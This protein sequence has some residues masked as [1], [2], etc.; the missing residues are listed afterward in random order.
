MMIENM[1]SPLLIVGPPRSGTSLVRDLVRLCP[2]VYVPPD[3]TQFLV[4]YIRRASDG[5]SR[6]DL[7]MFLDKTSFSIHMRR[8]GLWPDRRTLNRLL[9]VPQPQTAIPLLFAE[10]A[11]REGVEKITIW[12]DKTP[13]YALHLPLIRQIYPDLRVLAVVRDPRNVV[14]SMREAWG[15]SILRGSV[16]WRDSTVAMHEYLTSSGPE[17][18]RA[19]KYEELV[20]DPTS[21]MAGVAE[22]LNVDFPED[23][24]G[25]YY[26]EERWGSAKGSAGVV[27]GDPLR[28]RRLL[29]A[30][31]L[32]LIESV[33][34]DQL[35]LWGYRPENAQKAYSPGRFRSGMYRAIDA[36]RSFRAY[37]KDRGVLAG[38]R[39]KLAQRRSA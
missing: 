12:G 36:P 4:S 26:S 23:A 6:E 20:S 19:L 38:V 32:S 8:R 14:L 29:N 2:G 18:A 31:E 39:Y 7:A 21:V 28:Y 13:G 24:L 25:D 1:R 9:D 34:F 22:W 15:K 37:I 5:A 11:R 3:E 30:K 35:Q 16:L 10:L 17:R 27:R 33:T